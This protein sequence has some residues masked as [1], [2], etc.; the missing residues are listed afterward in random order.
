M[1]LMFDFLFA[2]NMWILFSSRCLYSK[3]CSYSCYINSAFWKDFHRRLTQ[4]GY[5]QSSWHCYTISVSQW[6]NY[7][8]HQ[9]M[10]C[11]CN[12]RTTS[13][14]AII[15]C[16][17]LL[18]NICSVFSLM[19]A[20]QDGRL[21]LTLMAVGEPTAVVPFQEKILLKLI[22]QPLMPLVG[23]LSLW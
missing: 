6:Q 11:I 5:V 19:Q 14:N 13:K 12:W 15:F 16:N 10:R 9:P 20:W 1:Y 7:F 8:S 18:F 3:K 23:L 22:V 21:L 2:G 17:H 4:R